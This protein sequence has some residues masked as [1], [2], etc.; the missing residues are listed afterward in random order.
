LHEYLD[1]PPGT[2]HEKAEGFSIRASRDGGRS[3]NPRKYQEDATLLERTLATETD[4]FLIS[5]Y[6]FYLAQSWRDCGEREKALDTYLKRATLGYCSEEVYISLLEAGDLMAAF[7]RPF[8]EVI[9]TYERAIQTV[10]AR[11]EALYAAANYCGKR[12]V[13]MKARNTRAAA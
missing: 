5:R 7:D 9:A 6:T 3:Q 2:S 4:P 10:P 11:A 13:T 1:A 12:A 8:D